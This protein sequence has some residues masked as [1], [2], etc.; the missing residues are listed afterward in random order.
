MV[1]EESAPPAQLECRAVGREAM[2]R[3]SSGASLSATAESESTARG[4]SSLSVSASSLCSFVAG[5]L[6]PLKASRVSSTLQKVRLGTSEDYLE[7]GL[8]Q[9]FI[10]APVTSPIGT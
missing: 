6:S 7:P 3:A 2:R 1:V 4:Q 10:H 8:I 5:D 9:A